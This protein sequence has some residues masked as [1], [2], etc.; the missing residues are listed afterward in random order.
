L[1]ASLSTFLYNEHVSYSPSLLH[2]SE[3]NSVITKM[4]VA[5]CYKNV[6]KDG[7]KL[8]QKTTIRATAVTKT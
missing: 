1:T 7:R 5:Y 2:S 4:E 3:P 6:R 8:N